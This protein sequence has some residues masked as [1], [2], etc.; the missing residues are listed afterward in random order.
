MGIPTDY[1][2]NKNFSK[3]RHF[4]DFIENNIKLFCSQCLNDEYESHV[5]EY[6]LE[7]HKRKSR[8]VDFLIKTKS[9]TDRLVEV[10]NPKYISELHAALGQ[11]LNYGFLY[12]K[13][14]ELIIVTSVF[15]HE[16][17]G[18]IKKNNLNV[19]VIGLDKEKHILHD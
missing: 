19:K 1:N 4:C 18:T 11:V 3:E 7:S 2:L 16:I 9:G 13:D 10:K 12:K 8:S 15:D 17:I 14:S 5:R 6:K